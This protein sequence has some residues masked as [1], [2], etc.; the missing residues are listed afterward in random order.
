MVI[1]REEGEKK[2]WY[3]LVWRM[4]IWSHIHQAT[5]QQSLWNLGSYKSLGE[6]FWEFILGPWGWKASTGERSDIS[7]EA[8]WHER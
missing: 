1:Y 8:K 6:D 5:P 3:P 7:P 2:S 4:D